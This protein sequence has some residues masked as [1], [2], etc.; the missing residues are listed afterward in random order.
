MIS[1]EELD[2][3]VETSLEQSADTTFDSAEG[4]YEP[5]YVDI[6]ATEEPLY[7]EVGEPFYENVPPFELA[8]D[9]MPLDVSAEEYLASRFA[10]SREKFESSADT[11]D[12][13]VAHMEVFP[14]APPPPP[15]LPPGM[16]RNSLT[17]V[18]SGQGSYMAM[19]VSN[20]SSPRHHY[21]S[22]VKTSPSKHHLRQQYVSPGKTSPSK[23]PLRQHYVS[24]GKTSPSKH[25]QQRHI[26]SPV[27]IDFNRRSP[28]KHKSSLHKSPTWQ[29]RSSSPS[30]FTPLLSPIRLA[31][32]TKPRHQDYHT[33]CDIR[34]PRRYPS[35]ISATGNGLLGASMAQRSDG[36]RSPRR[37]RSSSPEKTCFRAGVSYDCNHAYD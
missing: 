18:R 9:Q 15:P 32:P 22:P 5:R 4:D 17:R 21:V 1:V 10:E 27:T 3:T 8:T 31:S 19:N 25:H 28:I 11:D 2:T 16:S 37:Q 29:Q 13:E 20:S 14:P 34:S 6:D 23:H 30:R 24:P 35:R 26:Q 33:T 7:E 36:P 12:Y